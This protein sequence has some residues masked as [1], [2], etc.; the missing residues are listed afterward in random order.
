MPKT[1]DKL[2]VKQRK[3]VRNVAAGMSQAEA[4]RQAG[5]SARSA[6]QTA[7]ETMAIPDVREALLEAMKKAGIDQES[8][9]KVVKDA[10]E[11]NKSI[12]AVVGTDATGKTMD[13]V[14]VPD[15]PTRLKA[16]DMAVD[17]MGAKAPK[18][19]QAEVTTPEDYLAMLDDDPG[20][21][22]TEGPEG[23]QT[24]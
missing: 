4:A 2:T 12:S 22:D 16:A 7:S 14:D 9:S 6:R 23:S 24:D 18:K 15:H 17:I 21:E 19:I 1:R 8:I 10:M 5:Y 20:G 3:F 11:A 13:F